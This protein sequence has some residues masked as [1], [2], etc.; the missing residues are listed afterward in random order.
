MPKA[1]PT[2]GATTRTRSASSP[3]T[4][5]SSARARCGD[6][7]PSQTVRPP[8]S[9]A[10]SATS[11]RGSS[12]AGASRGWRSETL[13]CAAALRVSGAG[14]RQVSRARTA[15][16][17]PGAVSAGER[18]D[19]DPNGLCGIRRR[20]GG[21]R[22]DQRNWRADRGDGPDRQRFRRLRPD[23]RHQRID[24]G[25]SEAGKVRAGEDGNDAGQG[26]RFRRLDPG[27]PAVR[28]R[29]A[30]EGC[31]E[32]VG[33]TDVVGEPAL[34]GQER[35]VLDAQAGLSDAAGRCGWNF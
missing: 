27:D 2:S 30:H 22:H 11:P 31:V 1:P 7:L 34:P 33:D 21:L 23:F 12:A 15:S 32:A 10:A 16:V 3:S 29:A 17:P 25:S 28:L 20:R 9:L 4:A 24:R 13:A 5:A 19:F 8:G 6:W 35:P 26:G 14:V 18:F